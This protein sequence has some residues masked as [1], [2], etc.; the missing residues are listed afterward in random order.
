MKDKYK[1]THNSEELTIKP[2]FG[3]KIKFW[4]LT[5][6]SA[7]IFIIVPFLGNAISFDVSSV[8]Y[9][10]G[11][12]M[13]AIALYDFLFR[14]NVKFLF[15]KR[16]SA[17]YKINAPFFKSRLMAFDEMTIINTTEHGDMEYAIAR[18]KSQFLKHYSISDTFGSDK[19]SLQREADYVEEILNPILEFVRS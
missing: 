8:C 3:Y 7:A 18:K 5:V 9:A 14:L 6:L 10:L 17:I 16:T 1:F 12:V 2:Y 19:K 11:G 13:V 4:S 15:D